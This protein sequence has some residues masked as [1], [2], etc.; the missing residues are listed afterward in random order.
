[1]HLA[2]AQ[3]LL[4]LAHAQQ[5]QPRNANATGPTLTNKRH[6]AP[7]ATRLSHKLHRLGRD[8]HGHAAGA[9]DHYDGAPGP[10]RPCCLQ[11][12][13]PGHHA[14]CTA[15]AELGPG[16]H[17]RAR[18]HAHPR[19]GRRR[20]LHARAHTVP[21][22]RRLHTWAHARALHLA[23]KPAAA[24]AHAPPSTIEAGIVA[25]AATAGATA[26]LLQK[27]LPWLLL[28]L[29]V[30]LVLL[31]V[32]VLLQLLLPWLLPLLTTPAGLCLTPLLLRRRLLVLSTTSGACR[33][34]A[35][36]RPAARAHAAARAA[37][38]ASPTTPLSLLPG[39]HRVEVTALGAGT[40]LHATCG[41]M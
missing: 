26:T 9:H 14:G 27:L 28:V 15:G 24:S 16:L 2:L 22:L 35:R 41:P 10:T 25:R 18:A 36:W 5:L 3:P 4:G 1:M 30:L 6:D 34:V 20:L 33:C 23:I 37:A 8:H 38:A 19:R 21:L 39:V 17:G 13:R 31:L 40:T 12:L 29:L 7:N 32:L 11:Q